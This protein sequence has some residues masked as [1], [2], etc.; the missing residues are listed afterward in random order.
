MVIGGVGGDA[1]GKRTGDMDGDF[2]GRV[3]ADV[4][5]RSIHL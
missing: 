4:F 3:V 2:F 5:L 1:F